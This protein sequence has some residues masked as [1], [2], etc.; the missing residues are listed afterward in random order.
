[1][2]N[3]LYMSLDTGG[4]PIA[5]FQS[6]RRDFNFSNAFSYFNLYCFSWMFVSTLFTEN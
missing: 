3:A 2:Y 5:F 6:T 1:M 4:M